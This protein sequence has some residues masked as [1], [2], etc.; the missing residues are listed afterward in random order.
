MEW[1]QS[2]LREGS[3]AHDVLIL[4]LVVAAGLAVGGVRVAGITLGIGGVMFTGLAFGHF[5]FVMNPELMEFM[6][7]FGLILFVYAIGLQVGPG[8]FSSLRRQGLTMNLFAASIVLGG[9]AIALLIA[10]LGGVDFPAIVGVLSGAVTNTPSLG[11][12]QQALKEVPGAAPDVGQVVG[13]GYAVAY[14]FGILG[15]ILTMLLVRRVFRVD[16]PREAAEFQQEARGRT[17]PIKT[18]NVEIVNPNLAGMTV[19][20][21]AG[22]AGAGAVVTRVYHDGRQQLATPGS[23]L[24]VGDVL[25]V[26]GTAARLDGFE[27]IV[28]RQSDLELPTLPSPIT[29]RPVVVTKK[30]CVGEHLDALGLDDKY[31]V[32]V[33]RVVRAGVEFTVTRDL[34]VQFGDRLVVVGVEQAVERAAAELGDAVQELDRPHLVPIFLGIALGV[35]VGS[36]PFVLPTMP[37][38]VK[39]GLAGGPLVVAILLGRVGRIGPFVNY[40]PNPAKKVLAEFGIAIFLA[41]VGLKSG[42][43]FVEIL[44]TGSGVRWMALAALITF[45]PIMTA[46][47]VARAWKKLNYVS[48]CGLISGSMT[49]PP[50]LAYATDLVGSDAPSITYA[51]V[52]PLTMLLR[53]VIAQV[54]V[55]TLT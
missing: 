31:G 12:A 9:T 25:H 54:L 11:A 26:V 4:S 7:E 55:M 51:T 30:H 50:A 37:A 44:T 41:C 35:I 42:A 6:R 15:I 2:L 20:K 16:V 17:R 43:R 48:I 53:V 22:L 52:Y 24:A 8:F 33:T 40:M 36:I 3:V 45:V 5:G 47:V 27:V 23:V 21:L 1:L 28:G 46:A 13:L 49:D 39:L 18:R 14:P 34:R 10:R 38:P 19:E 32:I 29:F